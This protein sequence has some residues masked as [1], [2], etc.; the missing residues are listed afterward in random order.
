MTYIRNNASCGI[1]EVVLVEGPCAGLLQF[2]YYCIHLIRELL[3][4]LLLL[5][6]LFVC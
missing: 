5:F 4:L 1:V 2:L 3:Q 6:N